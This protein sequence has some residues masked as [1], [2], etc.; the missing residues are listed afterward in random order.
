VRHPQELFSGNAK[1]NTILSSAQKLEIQAILHLFSA[2][3]YSARQN[4]AAILRWTS[5]L[6]KLF[7]KAKAS[8][9]L[10]LPTL[11]TPWWTREDIRGN[12]FTYVGYDYY[13]TQVI[14]IGY[15]Y[16]F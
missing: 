1:L 13:E 3:P 2:R 4:R 8:Y 10:M 12:G 7:K 14:R 6:K 16:K 5:A 15:S 11:P 9:S